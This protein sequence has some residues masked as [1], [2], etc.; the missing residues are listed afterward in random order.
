MALAPAHGLQL[1]QAVTCGLVRHDG[2]E[3]AADFTLRQLG[4]LL[5]V[6]LEPPPH[7]VHGLAMKLG[8]SKPAISRALDTMGRQKLVARNRDANDRRKV[9]VQRTLGGALYVQRLA[10]TISAHA[11]DLAEV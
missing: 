10:E 7:T 6:Y 1:L 5:T 11:A 9:L 3:H 2:K 4:I 8:V